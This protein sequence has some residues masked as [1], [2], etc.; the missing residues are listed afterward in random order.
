MKFSVREA[1][2]QYID[3]ITDEREPDGKLHPSSMFG[4]L[5]QVVYS[6]RGTPQSEELDAASK[7]R[8]YIGHRLHEVA[9]RAVESYGEVAEFYPE[10]MVDVPEYQIL[11]HGD[12]LVKLKNGKWI[13]VELKSIRKA[14]MKFGMPKEHHV[15]QAIVYAWAAHDH[16]LKALDAMGVEKEIPP[17]GDDLIGVI[18]VY[19]EKEDLDIAEFPLVYKPA[20]KTRVIERWAAVKV[21]M[22]DPESLP[23]RLPL[24]K[25]G[26][27]PW[28]CNYCAFTDKCWKE[29]PHE[30][31]PKEIEE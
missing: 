24:L 11:G 5:R 26:K 27:K 31:Q 1:V 18:I 23:S 4:C 2:D 28:P 25:S 29:D 12:I 30:V 22:D 13:V 6:Q 10:F 7:R 19:I 16:G 3:S 14:A 8:F 17:L 21:Y 15:D 20:W 9:Q